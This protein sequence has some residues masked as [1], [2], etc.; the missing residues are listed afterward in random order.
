MVL[1]ALNFRGSFLWIFCLFWLSF[2]GANDT[3]SDSDDDED[4]LLHFKFEFNVNA[5]RISL[6]DGLFL[7]NA[8]AALKHPT[9][10]A[11]TLET[12]EPVGQYY[13]AISPDE[14]VTSA[15]ELSDTRFRQL[16][17]VEEV[18]TLSDLFGVSSGG[19]STK[20]PVPD[21]WTTRVGDALRDVTSS[22]LHMNAVLQNALK[23][24]PGV[25]GLETEYQS[26]TAKMEE[27]EEDD[28]EDRPLRVKERYIG[29]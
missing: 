8:S 12:F 11:E 29:I 9:T 23:E 16:F 26:K 25:A 24:A 3:D 27:Q 21:G 22:E 4:C 1:H 2:A 13:N 20:N 28:D 18:F 7:H 10:M 6:S 19:V 5:S 14:S 15:H 17:D